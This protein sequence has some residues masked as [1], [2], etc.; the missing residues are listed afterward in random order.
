MVICTID[1]TKLY[2]YTKGAIK[3]E[4]DIFYRYFV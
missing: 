3:I 4:N 2:I 1:E